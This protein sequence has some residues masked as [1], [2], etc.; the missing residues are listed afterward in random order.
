MGTGRV[1]AW[2]VPGTESLVK[3]HQFLEQVEKIPLMPGCVSGGQ[4]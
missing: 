4:V 1:N 2:Q 3:K